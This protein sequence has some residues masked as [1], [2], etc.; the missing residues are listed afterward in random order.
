VL[1]FAPGVANRVLEATWH[2]TQTVQTEADGSLR[3]RATVSGTIEI[4][5]W[6][7]SWGDDVEVLSPLTLRDDVAATHRRALERYGSA[8]AISGAAAR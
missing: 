1:R 7:L 3:W 4:R 8:T 2:P 5:L 6:I